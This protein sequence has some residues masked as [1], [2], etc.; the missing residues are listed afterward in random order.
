MPR[1]KTYE[2]SVF[3]NC[4]TDEELRNVQNAAAKEQQSVTEMLDSILR[5]RVQPNQTMGESLAKVFD[6]SDF[7]DPAENP[8]FQPSDNELDNIPDPEYTV[9]EV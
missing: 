6:Q 8:D 2:A 1:R 9:I 3:L 4:L 5:D 7:N